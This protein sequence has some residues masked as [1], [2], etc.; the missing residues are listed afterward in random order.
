MYARKEATFF[1]I[2][3]HPIGKGWP[4]TVYTLIDLEDFP[5]VG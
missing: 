5:G 1:S 2:Q 3:S 4:G